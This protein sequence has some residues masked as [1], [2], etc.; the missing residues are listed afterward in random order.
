MCAQR[1]TGDPVTPLDMD[2]YPMVFNQATPTLGQ[3]KHLTIPSSVDLPMEGK[4]EGREALQHEV[5]LF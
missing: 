3:K 5:S 2:E 4:Q 1:W